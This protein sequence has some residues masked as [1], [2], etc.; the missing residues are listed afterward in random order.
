MAILGHFPTIL[1]LYLG[2]SGTIPEPRG[3]FGD[4]IPEH[5]A[6]EDVLPPTICVMLWTKNKQ[7]IFLQKETYTARLR[8]AWQ[9]LHTNVRRSANSAAICT[10]HDDLVRRVQRPCPTALRTRSVGGHCI[11]V[12]GCT[13]KRQNEPKS[14]KS[15]FAFGL[16]LHK[17]LFTISTQSRSPW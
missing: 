11:A 14:N 8:I 17:K 5:S 7:I 4:F 6:P 15:I 12:D 2:H 1:R 10:V 13:I 9:R 3:S 16:N